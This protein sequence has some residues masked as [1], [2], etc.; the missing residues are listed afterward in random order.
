MSIYNFFL[1]FWRECEKEPFTITETALYHYL[2]NAANRN[3]WTMPIRCPTELMACQLRTTKQNIHKARL[4]LKER[5][6]IDFEPGTGKGKYATY[7]LCL[8]PEVLSGQSSVGMSTPLPPQLSVR[9]SPLKDIEIDKNNRS[10]HAKDREEGYLS[11]SILKEILLADEEWHRTLIVHLAQQGVSVDEIDLSSL[12]ER[13]FQKL[14]VE[15]I[16]SK[17]E[18]DCRSHFYNWLCR[19][20]KNNKNNERYSA[21]QRRAVDVT[22]ASSESYEGPY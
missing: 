21:N 15:G 5:G 4:S 20:T 19:I 18:T 17:T 2:L 8:L 14:S 3:R 11:I 6:L 9:L 7:T 12:I 13:F 22:S 16:T 1:P 10:L